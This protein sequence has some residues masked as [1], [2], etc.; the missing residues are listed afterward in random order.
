MIAQ[1]SAKNCLILL[2]NVVLVLSNLNS[3]NTWNFLSFFL[4]FQQK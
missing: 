2:E 3:K 4:D 1:K